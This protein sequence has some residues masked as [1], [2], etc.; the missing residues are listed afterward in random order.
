MNKLQRLQAHHHKI[1]DLFISG[2]TIGE[3][4]ETIGMSTRNIALI[5]RSPLFQSEYS[6]RR[7]EFEKQNDDREVSKI[8]EAKKRLR[9]AAVEAAEVHIGIVKDEEQDPRIRQLSANEILN[10]SMGDGKGDGGGQSVVL[11]ADKIQ[12]LAVAMQEAKEENDG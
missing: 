1:I 11:S 4:A 10:R 8:D 12:L 7:R 6:R 5:Q 2:M 9:E 3:V